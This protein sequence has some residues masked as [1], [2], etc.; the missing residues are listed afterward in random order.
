MRK[1][2]DAALPSAEKEEEATFLVVLEVEG[3]MC[4]ANC[5]ATVR[6]A[7]SACPS[8]SRAHVSFSSASATVWLKAP[9]RAATSTEGSVDENFA[10][11]KALY[12]PDETAAAVRPLIDALSDVGFG[13]RL[14]DAAPPLECPAPI[15]G[16][17]GVTNRTRRVPADTDSKHESEN[18]NET[19]FR[20]GRKRSLGGTK[21]NAGGG[22]FTS[23]FTVSG[24]SCAA[25]VNKVE[26]R[27]L[28]GVP[29]AVSVS[30]A[31]LLEKAVVS[32]DPAVTSAE[33][34][35]AAARA[36]VEGMGYRFEVLSG[37]DNGCLD[38]NSTPLVLKVKGSATSEPRW[39]VR[40]ERLIRALPGVRSVVIDP[41][42]FTIVMQLAGE[43]SGSDARARVTG[44]TGSVEESSA[45]DGGMSGSRMGARD[46]VDYLESLGF[47]CFIQPSAASLGECD[48]LVH[49][50]QS[51]A[52]VEAWR[53][54]LGV[55]AL[56]TMPLMV[57][58]SLEEE[59]EGGWLG[60]WG[61][62]CVIGGLTA[63]EA[64]MFLLATP[65]QFL[66]GGRFYRSA[67]FGLSSG[68]IG[69]DFLISLG[70]TTAYAFSVAVLLVKA[71]GDPS[72]P[73]PCTFETAAMLLLFVALGK[74][75]EAAARGKTGASLIALLRLQPSKALLVVSKAPLSATSD[76]LS[77][78]VRILDTA[79]IQKG[80]VIRVPP[81]A[82]VPVDGDVICGQSYVD[83]SILT[84]ESMPVAKGA[85][86]FVYGGSTNQSFGALLILATRVGSDTALRQIVALVTAAQASRPPIQAF[87][88]AV[89]GVF[90]PAIIAVSVAVFVGWYTVLTSSSAT[91]KAPWLLTAGG[92][93]FLFALM[94][95][96]AVL[97][98]ACPCAMGLATP[99]AVMVGTGV[100]THQG[101]LI[102]EGAAFECAAK[103]TDV[104]F[105]KTGTL[106]VGQ[107]VLTDEVPLIPGLKK[108]AVLHAAASVETLSEHP[109]ARG[110]MM[111]AASRN[112][113]L[114]PAQPSSFS[115]SPGQGVR[116]VL[117]A[118]SNK[119]FMNRASYVGTD[120]CTDMEIV[121]GTR[122]WIATNGTDVSSAA[123]VAMLKLEAQGKTAVL[124]AVNRMVIGALAVSDEPR[125]EAKE[126]VRRLHSMGL[127]VW[128][129]TGDNK[130]SAAAAADAVG[131]PSNNVLSELLPAAKARKIA[132]MQKRQS[133]E[134]FPKSFLRG[135]RTKVVAMVGDGVNDSPALV[136][137]HVG[138]AVG[139]G[140]QVAVEAADM[141][142]VRS[143]LLAVPTA[144]DL[145]RV[146]FRRI[147]L[148]FVWALSYN[149]IALPLASGILLPSF[150][151]QLSPELA[152]A[153]MASS[154]V[155]V[156]LS[157]LS[158]RF[159]KAPGSRGNILCSVR[160]W[161]TSCCRLV[162]AGQS[163]RRIRRC[164]WPVAR[165]NEPMSPLEKNQE[166]G[167]WKGNW[168]RREAFQNSNGEEGLP[169]LS[170]R[171][172]GGEE[173]RSYSSKVVRRPADAWETE[174]DGFEHFIL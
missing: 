53:N 149:I 48:L 142:L 31:L 167:C 56:F 116:C 67:Y 137:A 136:E 52:E 83:E 11:N 79:L 91:S 157:S 33:N 87:S 100:A 22:T 96:V 38:T 47:S 27:L 129:M 173:C 13:A 74:W 62:H 120:S 109:M 135:P 44:A 42:T 148:N 144:L 111:A 29:G 145:S 146:V 106:T 159:Y 92:D 97:V 39:P 49:E 26:K 81:G 57:V 118:P 88:D 151:L 117:A 37:G 66:V 14:V 168:W 24:M 90:A 71:I 36:V 17:Y 5:A 127:T 125:P 70:T 99:T 156:V 160:G 76:A 7:L 123:E 3:M 15:V 77:L 115:N 147:W 69:M 4:E 165:E 138:I 128:L 85:G 119:L 30:V 112:L 166:V 25:C 110:I 107:L 35:C 45:I 65:V 80:D 59:G 104:V 16:D 21:A 141:V 154:S 150:G 46:I 98:V 72:F 54:L 122:K 32:W 113:A 51:R 8:V 82:R 126:A 102:K 163:W 84:G 121:V 130:Y 93:P 158:L 2:D 23:A 19:R 114:F 6:R 1:R 108:H 73:E 63:C 58:H 43:P 172:K 170:S 161:R 68:T 34:V 40:A 55:A 20:T 139:A 86:D 152:A 9:S 131:I 169:L 174:D 103:V 28:S 50:K 133:R 75:L 162:C 132:H 153:F 105:D 61:R 143:D 140:A 95:A 101:I 18:V 12:R 124:V 164:F 60:V 89:A 64:V 94:S 155:M 78:P 10:A 41:S 171:T 134:S